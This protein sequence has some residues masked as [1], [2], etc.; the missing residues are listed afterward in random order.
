[1]RSLT[2]FNTDDLNY[3]RLG[4]IV[5]KV[6]VFLVAWIFVWILLTNMSAVV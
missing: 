5:H 6:T 2:D 3:L 1:M 4:S